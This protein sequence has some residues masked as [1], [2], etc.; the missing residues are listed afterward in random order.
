MLHRVLWPDALQTLDTGLMLSAYGTPAAL[1]P[2]FVVVTVIGGGW[3]LLAVLPFAIA[4]ATRVAALWLLG[5]IVAQSAVVAAL[6]ALIQRARPCDALGWCA[7]IAVGPPGGYSFPSG[8]A[9]GSFAFAA[10][11]AVRAPRF[12]APAFAWATLVAW[13]RCV[14]GVHYPSDVLAGALVGG[15]VGA[16]F[17]RASLRPGAPAP[18]GGV[19]R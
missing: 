8:H 9:A 18:P 19:E 1:V 10:F 6:K 12:A 4:R 11:I 3:G 17:A 7:P 5:A 14:L 13:S 15:L 16:L 2:I